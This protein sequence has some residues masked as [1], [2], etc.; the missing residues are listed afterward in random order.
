V[1]ALVLATGN[2]KK[3]REL[4]E[5]AAG[6]Y[7]VKTLVDVGLAH[8]CIDE[9]A[10]SFEGNARIKAEA[11]WGALADG[12]AT[13]GVLAVLADDSG[14][15]VD[16][17]EGRPGVRSARFAADHG[18]GAGDDDNNRLLLLLLEAVPEERRGARFVCAVAA[19]LQGGTLLTSAGTV[20]GRVARDLRGSGGFGYDPLFL[21]D[22][23]PGK[24]MAE[25]GADEKH[26]ISHRGR[27]MRALLAQLDQ[28]DQLR[29]DKQP[30]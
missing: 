18:T 11:V 25:L 26:A 5:L 1:S 2:A 21:P 4:V 28:L 10:D 15:A 14:I 6:R 3:R 19:R 9:S 20:E 22:K 13:S 27:A 16:A 30:G 12:G 29:G 17:L 23:A 8:L 7:H 24:R